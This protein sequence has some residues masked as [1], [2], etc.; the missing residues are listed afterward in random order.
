V[1]LAVDLHKLEKYFLPDLNPQGGFDYDMVIDRQRYDEV[2]ALLD[3][4][5]LSDPVIVPEFCFIILWIEKELGVIDDLQN[6]SGKYQRM[7]QEI[8]AVKDY[9]L[10]H[11]ITSIS[12][13]GEHGREKPGKPLI[14]KEEINIDRLCDGIRSVFR[15][16]FQN[17]ES[18]RL[19]K[20]RK[21][22][23][24]R[25]MVKIRNNIM[26]YFTSIPGTDSLSLEQESD[27]IDRLT[28]IAC[29]SA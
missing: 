5:G 22:W 27:I 28:A 25:K 3:D 2:E 19:S 24:K 21:K 7:W 17:D 13:M 1:K 29:A 10:K 20:G 4:Y 6:R 12:L 14:I 16:E 8:D 15:E 11:R 23:K 26:N 18:K 9:L